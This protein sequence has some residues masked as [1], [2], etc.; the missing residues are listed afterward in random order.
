MSQLRVYVDLLPSKKT[1]WY[2]YPTPIGNN[3]AT[4]R[5]LFPFELKLLFVVSDKPKD[6]QIGTTLVN[7]QVCANHEL[8]QAVDNE[9]IFVRLDSP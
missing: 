1:A 8:C 2:F 5:V 9:L 3:Q 6:S 4:L 7:H